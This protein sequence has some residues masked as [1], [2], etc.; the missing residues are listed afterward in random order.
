MANEQTRSPRFTQEEAAPLIREATGQSFK[1]GGSPE[2]TL[3]ASHGLGHRRGAADLRNADGRA[4]AAR[5]M[6][7]CLI[8][9]TP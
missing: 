7:V 8:A 5:V 1:A 9:P 3:V 6:A 4:Q 2:L